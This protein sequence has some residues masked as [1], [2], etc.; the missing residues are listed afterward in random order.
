[1]NIR[2]LVS[3][4]L[5]LLLG[6]A[7]S[8]ITVKDSI[9][10]TK[11]IVSCNNVTVN[12][13]FQT[14]RVI[15]QYCWDFGDGSTACFTNTNTASHKY[16][17]PGSYT[18]SVYV[19]SG[20]V[21]DTFTCVEPIVVH[22]PPVADFSISNP[23]LKKYA[24][25]KAKFT[26]LTTKGDGDSLKYSWSLNYNDISVDTNLVYSFTTPQTCNVA[27]TVTDNFGCTS[28]TYQDIVIRDSAQIGEF[29]Y[30]EGSCLPYRSA[31][32]L[33]MNFNIVDDTLIVSGIISGNCGASKTATAKLINDTVYIRTF[34]TGNMATCSC[35]FNFLIKLG[36]I[37]LDSIPV[38]FDGYVYGA[39]RSTNG[40]NDALSNEQLKLYPNPASTE[41]VI[42]Y[43]SAEANPYMLQV[44]NL[45]GQEVYKQAD[46]RTSSLS[47]KT[48]A[49]A[50]GEYFVKSTDA[51]GHVYSNKLIVKE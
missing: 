50:A 44:Y 27:L 12:C 23:E 8:A 5:L 11:N 33:P 9:V 39:N 29:P 31:S 15:N 3:A 25:Y 17:T 10:L 24:P 38:N 40:L 18:L 4:L 47:V 36:G 1:M 32:T 35:G 14:S 46:V 48:S 16:Q 51:A 34:E 20:G 45:Q 26:N 7:V 13:S 41:F 6:Q 19:S 37:L 43:P 49:F 42:E 2:L 30:I 21:V 22:N 28:S